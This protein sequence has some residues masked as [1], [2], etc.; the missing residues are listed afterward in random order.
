MIPVKRFFRNTMRGYRILRVSSS[1]EP[2]SPSSTRRNWISAYLYRQAYP[3]STSLLFLSSSE[4]RSTFEP[5]KPRS[6]YYRKETGTW[7]PRT[8]YLVHAKNFH[9]ERDHKLALFELLSPAMIVK[10]SHVLIK[11]HFVNVPN[12]LQHGPITKRVP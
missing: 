9:L 2:S 1:H 10:T 5:K 8:G 12:T 3:P 4:I 7:I 6:S 11:I